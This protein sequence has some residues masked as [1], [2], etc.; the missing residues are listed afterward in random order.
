MNTTI[1]PKAELFDGGPPIEWERAVFKAR[2]RVENVKRT[3]QF[4][5]LVS[6]LP[7]ALIAVAQ[8]LFQDNSAA[9]SFFKDFAAYAR[10]L[11]AAPL[12]VLAESDWIPRLGGV[13]RQFKEAGLIISSEEN[14][15]DEAIKS[16]KRLLNSKVASIIIL[17]L[18]YTIVFV[19]TLYVPAH[20]FP[21]WQRSGTGQFD[22]SIAGWVHELISLP[23]LLLLLIGWIWRIFLWGRFLYL[24]QG[25]ELR[26]IPG[27]PDHVG[28]LKFLSTSLRGFRLLSFSIG[29]MVAGP[30]MN[31][32]RAGASPVTFK[33]LVIGLGLFV[34]VLSA[35]PLTIFVRKL[36]QT[37]KKGIFAYGSFAGSL[38]SEFEKKWINRSEKLNEG[39]LGVPD[40][41]ATVDLYS[42]VANVYEMKELPF[43]WRN[44]GNIV[45]AALAPFIPAALMVLPVKD[46]VKDLSKLV[47]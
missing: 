26:L 33:N 13:A 22:L 40:F 9:A 17:V 43:G 36:R 42:V 19:S 34:I 38:G 28:G 16:T 32:I 44:L 47:F 6:W 11:I 4:V 29:A 37:K 20:Y 2:P 14:R 41:S 10:Y 46:I 8:W 24:M 35:G 23:L 27:H 31:Q 7:L 30:V 45:A 21:S 12:L 39:V 1:R 25:L 15:Y 3:A 18:V 5:L